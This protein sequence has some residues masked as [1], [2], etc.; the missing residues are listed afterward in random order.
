[1]KNSKRFLITFFLSIFF[2][3]FI[4]NAQYTKLLDFA[5][6]TTGSYPE[7][8]LISDSTYL[9][10]MTFAGGINNRGV[11]FKMKPD[12]T[13]FSKLFDFD[14]VNG[15]NPYG[16]VISDGTFLYGMTSTG[17]T[18]NM[19][20]IFK[21][22]LN[23]TGYSKIFDFTGGINGGHP[24][25]DLITD[26]T[27]LYG[28]T[29]WGGS[30]SDGMI[31]KIKLD[32]TGYSKVLDFFNDSIGAG[33]GGD[34]FFDGTYLY[35]MISGSIATGSIFKIKP[36]GTEY[37][38]LHEF[39]GAANGRHPQGDLISDGTFLYGMTEYGG[40]N[41]E[42]IIFKIKLD[43]T[44]YSKLLDFDSV[45]GGYPLGSLIFDGNFLYATT[46][47]GGTKGFG[48]IF[49]IKTDG[50]GYSKLFDF[51]SLYGIYPPCDLI[52]DGTF[53]YGM[54]SRG[55]QN[56]K[57]VI[58]KIPITTDGVGISHNFIKPNSE[59]L[60]DVYPNPSR[61]KFQLKISNQQLAKDKEY[62][63]EVYNLIG[64]KIYTTKTQQQTFD[65]DISNSTK[66]M[67]FIRMTDGENFYSEKIV[68]E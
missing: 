22:K 43:G 33:P 41:D 15:R 65:I 60:F 1:M 11:I 58:F 35:G 48:T 24:C 31:F 57:G 18:Y 42:G 20:V 67:Y 4:A 46:Q 47:A 16:S 49:K 27:F 5:G 54:T 53:L 26:G 40:Y 25:G 21:I 55:G 23:G 44:G 59:K 29:C 3:P 34:L 56:K 66:G 52:S 10:S 64:E 28:M 62:T 37:A 30:N 8:S 39:T 2:L 50:T 61:G 63:I 19:G 68:I 17:G 12:G 9:Y 45:N 51:D 38:R 7:G 14:S 32:G 13:E 36:D 6:A